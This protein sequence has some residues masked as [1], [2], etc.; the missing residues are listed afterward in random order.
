MLEL[1]H[2]FPADDLADCHDAA[3]AIEALRPAPARLQ[4]EY[5][6]LELPGWIWGTMALC[7][8]A[9]FAGLLAATGRDGEAL[10]A[11]AISLGYSAMYFGTGALLFGMNPPP[12]PAAF[13]R[14]IGELQAW[15]GPM[16]LKAVAAQVL[17]VPA[18]LALFGIAAPLIR[19]IVLD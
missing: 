6:D 17:V 10:F 14:G 11:I 16:P 8:G 1:A 18:C 13:T 5:V 19:A 15:T 9:F 4:P 7:Y 12:A 3:V 2:T